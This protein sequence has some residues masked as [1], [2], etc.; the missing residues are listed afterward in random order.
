MLPLLISH[1]TLFLHFVVVSAYLIFGNFLL[2]EKLFY[3]FNVNQSFFYQLG[4]HFCCCCIKSL[5]YSIKLQSIV[6]PE[7]L[8]ETCW[9]EIDRYKPLCAMWFRDKRYINIRSY[10]SLNLEFYFKYRND[11]YNTRWFIPPN[12][13]LQS[14]S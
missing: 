11:Y 12:S 3:K 10:R 4:P 2:D 8:P 14:T 5:K 6:F 7:T 1:G 13:A 9:K